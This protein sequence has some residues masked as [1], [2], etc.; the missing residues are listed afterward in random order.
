MKGRHG[1]TLYVA[2]LILGLL[3]GNER[4]RYTGGANLESALHSEV[5]SLLLCPS[6]LVSVDAF[7]Y[8]HDKKH[9]LILILNSDS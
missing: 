9:I 8:F 4:R 2:V 5:L 6:D 1:T 7:L 3:P